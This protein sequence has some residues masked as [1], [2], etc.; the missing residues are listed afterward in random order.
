MNNGISTIVCSL[1]THA[2]LGHNKGGSIVVFGG[3]TFL[4]CTTTVSDVMV[5]YNATFIIFW[6]ANIFLIYI[7]YYFLVTIK[8]IWIATQIM[9]ILA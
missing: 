8:K 6:L 9:S 4:F 1:A 5:V 3:W 7:Y 2:F